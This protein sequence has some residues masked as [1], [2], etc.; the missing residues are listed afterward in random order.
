MCAVERAAKDDV[1]CACATVH[2]DGPGQAHRA[3]EA[4]V[5]VG[6]RDVTGQAVRAGAVLRKRARGD[7]VTCG[8]RGEHARVGHFDRATAIQTSVQGQCLTGVVEGAGERDGTVKLR[9]HAAGLLQEACGLKHIV[10]IQRGDRLDRHRTQR[11]R[12][13]NRR[14][15]VDVARA[16]RDGQRTRRAVAIERAAKRYGAVRG[17]D[18][19]VRTQRHRTGVGLSATGGDRAAVESRGARNTEAAKA[20]A[21]ADGSSKHRIAGDAECAQIAGAAIVAA[22][23]RA[24][25]GGRASSDG[26]VLVQHR[27][28]S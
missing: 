9:Q 15:K 4:D 5:A 20:V 6:R 24:A 18:G 19:R 28:T 13:T 17:G 12:V 2:G 10:R 22:V 1:A 16:S 23:E 3:Q 11:G 7:D 27:R 21:V 8:G 14:I 26:S 25:K